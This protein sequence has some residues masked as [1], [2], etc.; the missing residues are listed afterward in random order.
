M[1]K[2]ADA[3]IHIYKRARTGRIRANKRFVRRLKSVIATE[4]T[5]RVAQSTAHT[6]LDVARELYAQGGY[7]AVTVRAVAAR[8]GITSGAI[9]KHYSSKED[10]FMALQERALELLVDFENSDEIVAP[11]EHLRLY[12][13]RYYEF[14]QQHPEY[15]TMLWVDS[16]VPVLDESKPQYRGIQRLREDNRRRI[17]RCVDAGLIP[18]GEVPSIARFLM[19]TMH[20]CAVLQIAHERRFSGPPQ[21]VANALD[22][23]LLAVQHG[24]LVTTETNAS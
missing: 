3:S 10:L 15:F 21:W 2:D 6:I 24:L 5:P 20:G 7:S 13:W 19:V 12:Y 8:V 23:S 1:T 11:L 18:P 9:Y 16:S 17:E 14:S 4:A 22:A